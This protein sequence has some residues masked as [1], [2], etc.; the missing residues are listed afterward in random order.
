LEAIVRK[1]IRLTK[2]VDINEPEQIKTILANL[3]WKPTTKN[4]TVAIYTKFL[5]YIGKHGNRHTT[6]NRTNMLTTWAKTAQSTRNASKHIDKKEV[7]HT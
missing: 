3:E 5:E 6:Q 1:L 7:Y 2:S 4:T